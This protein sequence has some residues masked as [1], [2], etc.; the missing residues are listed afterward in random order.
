MKL[1]APSDKRTEVLADIA[2][3]RSVIGFPPVEEFIAAYVDERLGDPAL[4]NAYL[5]KCR[6]AKAK[7]SAK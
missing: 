1:K 5:A 2:R 3:R 6:K 4:M 7:R